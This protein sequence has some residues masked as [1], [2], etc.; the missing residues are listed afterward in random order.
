MYADDTVIIGQSDEE[1]QQALRAIEK[2][3]TQWKL[4]VNCNKAKVAVFWKSLMIKK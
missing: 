3:C 4:D 1:I 2:Y